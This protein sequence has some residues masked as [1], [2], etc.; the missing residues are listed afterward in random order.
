MDSTCSSLSFT[1][2]ASD[3]AKRA[4]L[5]RMRCEADAALDEHSGSLLEF[6]SIEFEDMPLIFELL[7]L[8][9]GRTTDFSF[10]GIYMWIDYLKYSYCI[11][12]NT[13]FIMGVLE[14]DRNVV[15]FSLPVGELP[16][17]RAVDMLRGYCRAHGLTLE[18]SAVPEYAVAEFEK[19][20]PC[21]ITELSDW[22][23]YLYDAEKLASLSGK[24]MSKKRNHVNRFMSLYAD[25]WTFEPL[26]AG[27][28][29][30]A[31]RFLDRYAAQ[32]DDNQ[33]AR[34]ELELSRRMV[35]DF[36]QICAF[37]KGGILRV[38]GEICALTL[39]DVKGDTLFVHIEK[40]LRDIDGSYEAVNKLFAE[41]MCRRNPEIRF[42]NREDDAGDE[43]LRN[44]KR[45]YHPVEVLRKYNIRF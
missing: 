19:L 42:I 43:G 38:D 35:T 33:Q 11:V 1:D 12:E 17:A 32:A 16:L 45:S 28:C 40:A 29:A 9:P 25:R 39:G 36:P 13:L 41:Y 23:D 7:K 6:K 8:E 3:F 27:A 37:E 10:G 20:N 5:W 15:A 24:K 2:F 14:D 21:E 26:T 4:A 18:F 44:A 31:L 22:G 30:E 34:D